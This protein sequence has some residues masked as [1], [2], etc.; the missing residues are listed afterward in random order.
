MTDCE[1]RWS[2]GTKHLHVLNPRPMTLDEARAL[3]AI[4]TLAVDV[5]CKDCGDTRPATCH[6]EMPAAAVESRGAPR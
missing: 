5:N 1:H 3:G 2:S 4:V 6:E